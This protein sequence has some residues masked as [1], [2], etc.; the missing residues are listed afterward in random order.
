MSLIGKT[1]GH[2][3]ITSQLGK[4]GMGEVFQAKDQKLGRDVAIKVLPEEFARDADRVARFQR[5]AKLLASLNHPNIAAIHGLEESGGTDFLVLELVDGETL[6][7][8]IKA[9]PIPVEESLK[10]ALQIA[11]A[12]EAAHEKGVI[13][14]DLKPANIKVTPDGKV[15]VLD[16]GLAKAFAGDREEVNLSNSPTLSN[17]ATQQG[18][19]LGTAAYMPPE[20]ACGKAADKRV[21]VWAFGVV[22]YEM[23]TGRSLFA[24]E[25]VSQTLARV[26]ERQPDFSTLPPNLN[27]KITEIMQ[28][29]LVKEAR[30]R[31]HDIADVR[32][33]PEKAFADPG[34]VLHKPVTLSEPRSSLRTTLLWA[35]SLVLIGTIAGVAVWHFKPNNTTE[36]KR[37][38]RFDYELPTGQQFARNEISGI[39]FAVSPDGSRFVY[40]TTEGLQMRSME[41]L[42]ARLIPGTDKNSI[43]PFFSPDSQWIGYFS[44]SDQK[45][46]KIAFSGG[47]PVLLCDVGPFV[48]GASWDSDDT[49]VYSNL[50]GI[51]R[52]SA[53]GGTPENLIKGSVA[54]GAKEGFPVFPQMLPDGKGLLFTNLFSDFADHQIVVQSLKSG[55]RKVLFKGGRNAVYLP[56]GHIVYTPSD[57]NTALFAVP[58]D[59]EKLE[60]TGGS[61]SMLGGIRGRAFSKSGTLVYLP[62]AAAMPFAASGRNVVWVDRQGK[63]EPI[64]ASPD[65]YEA[66]RISPDGN[67]VALT[68]AGGNDDI[69][70]WDIPHKT[71]TKLTF[72]KTGGLRAFNFVIPLW[73]GD[74][75]RIVFYS[76]RGG[77][78]G[79]VYSKSADG[80]GDD[81]LLAS[82]SDKEMFGIFPWSLSRDGKMLAVQEMSLS[83]PGL[84][85]GILSMEGKREIKGLL[86]EKHTETEPQISPDGRYMAYQSDESGKGEIFVCTFPDVIK[87]KWQVST[88]GGGSPLWSRDGRELFYRSGDVT[89][90]VA[91]ETEPTFQLGN[92]KIIFEGVYVSN[93]T[94]K[95][96]LT[97]WDISPDGKRFLM[98]KPAASTGAT[99]TTVNPQPKITIVLN[100]T[101]ELKPRV[102][103]K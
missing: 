21:D 47:G 86:Q 51:M 1:L 103:V 42:D 95:V 3:Q 33:D 52:V 13:H 19:I 66:L 5:E 84:D 60:V 74:G 10:L 96:I 50:S 92:P 12:L 23:L 98:I 58:F 73:T 83:P 28:R 35:A 57:D 94:Q 39:T 16:F 49:I 17:A 75:K 54:R 20:Q 43:Q 63:E 34:G 80:I 77:G 72:D 56:T 82:G 46:K 67:K 90:A 70:V 97:P 69:W 32:I 40:A 22:L 87:G 14:R 55:E 68:V 30:N 24:G 101:E 44:Q 36:P 81:E 31:C 62:Q 41:E 100:W 18:V 64:G 37:V 48:L 29:C 8:R 15:K 45:L 78:S 61:V 102:P 59:L 65:A 4:G 7:D 88:S 91:V 6:A 53:N 26:L 89:M 25:S 79:S 99:S 85:I 27:P 93:A 71:R 76:N 2:Y 11:E 9:G 38:T